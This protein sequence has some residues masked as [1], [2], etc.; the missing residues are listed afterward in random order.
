MEKRCDFREA[1]KTKVNVFEIF[2]NEAAPEQRKF[3][4]KNNV[5]FIFYL[6]HY[7]LIFRPIYNNKI[8]RKAFLQMLNSL[9]D[10]VG[11]S[12]NLDYTG[13]SKIKC[14]FVICETIH[15]KMW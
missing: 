10:D 3:E 8:N 4:E 14:S 12:L 6:L 15:K 5:N 13:W 1:A 2:S 9:T 11:V 7:F